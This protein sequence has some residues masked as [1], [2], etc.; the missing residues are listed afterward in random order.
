ML[1]IPAL[2]FKVQAIVL[3]NGCNAWGL[4]KL[5]INSENDSDS[6]S[7]D[8]SI[9]CLIILANDNQIPSSRKPAPFNVATAYLHG[10]TSMP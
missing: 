4:L 5:I 6:L 10:L 7:V 3:N 2:G 8:F 9:W 1:V